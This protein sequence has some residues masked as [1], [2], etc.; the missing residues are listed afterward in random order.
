MRRAIAARRSCRRSNGRKT[1]SRLTPA[2][3]IPKSPRRRE[4]A[5][6]QF[7]QR[8]RRQVRSATNLKPRSTI[9]RAARNG[10][11]R[12]VGIR[13]M[14]RSRT[15]CVF[16]RE[17]PALLLRTAGNFTENKRRPARSLITLQLGRHHS[18]R[19]HHL[20]LVKFRNTLKVKHDL[21]SISKAEARQSCSFQSQPRRRGYDKRNELKISHYQMGRRPPE[22]HGSPRDGEDRIG[23]ILIG[24]T[25]PAS[26]SSCLLQ[27]VSLRSGVHLRL[28]MV[29]SPQH[30]DARM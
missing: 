10:S 21:R 9:R 18:A 4:S 11:A 30:S 8:R 27:F 23:K 5:N 3:R 26:I 1:P 2:C 13:L 14:M 19:G 25:H 28:A 6:G 24:L 22:H 7:G 16:Y 15:S 17:H 12:R 29:H 20:L